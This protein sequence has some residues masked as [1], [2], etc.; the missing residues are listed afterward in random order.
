MLG[1]LT[2]VVGIVLFGGYVLR[3]E[4]YLATHTIFLRH[5][6]HVSVFKKEA[7]LK[8][9]Q[10]PSKYSFSKNEQTQIEE[11]F[12]SVTDSLEIKE[13]V[14]VIS[15]TAMLTDGCRSFPV[16]IQGIKSMQMKW[17]YQHPQVKLRIP[18]LL[19]MQ[20]GA[21][22]WETTDALGANIS[23]VLWSFFDKG[24]L[25]SIN[26]ETRKN[27]AGTDN[28]DSPETKQKLSLTNELQI[29]SQ[30]FYG[31]LGL[32]DTTVVGLKYSGFSLA[33]EVY[34]TAP[35][36]LVQGLVKS[37]NIHKWSI[38]FADASSV[39]SKIKKLQQAFEQKNIKD[40]DII[41]YTDSRVSELYVGNMTF[42]IIMFLFFLVLICGVVVL[43]VFNSLQIAFLERQKDISIYKSIGFRNS[44]ITQIFQIEYLLI[45]LACCVIAGATSWGLANWNN[46]M[47]FRFQAPGYSSSI[48]FRLE[49]SVT[50]IAFVFI[51]VILLVQLV[52]YLQIQRLLKR[53]SAELM[54]FD[55]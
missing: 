30:D 1:L 31:G 51:C 37:D 34:L 50:Y 16:W 43:T 13:I 15:T 27:A 20:A 28:C 46:S 21:G 29:F 32:V 8:Y 35:F 9:Q 6:G 19:K 22:Y 33:D 52:S 44:V 47:N 5:V 4:G 10:N 24:E 39:S 49:P 41:P 45:S 17:I 40:F 42:V 48:Q 3:M 18:E 2:G 55:S 54:R 7:I 11:V 23:P 38:Y 12:R 53:Q 36:E 25:S 26:D 14:P